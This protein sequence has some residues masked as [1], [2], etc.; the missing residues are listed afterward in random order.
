MIAAGHVVP[1]QAPKTISGILGKI[2]LIT[3]FPGNKYPPPPLSSSP[4]KS[5]SGKNPKILSRFIVIDNL[6]TN[7]KAAVSQDARTGTADY[8][9]LMTKVKIQAFIKSKLVIYD[10]SNKKAGMTDLEKFNLAQQNKKK[11]KNG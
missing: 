8:Q 2:V 10:R 4:G 9:K 3:I 1:K 11:E 7:V 6:V 5:G